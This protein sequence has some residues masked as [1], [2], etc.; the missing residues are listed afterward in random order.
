M[1]DR[2]ALAVF[3]VDAEGRFSDLR[4]PRDKPKQAF[5][6]R[7]CSYPVVGFFFFLFLEI[8]PEFRVKKA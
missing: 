5:L 7:H 1:L 4:A 2:S 6:T 3:L 8:L